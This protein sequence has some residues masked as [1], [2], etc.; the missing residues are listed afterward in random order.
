MAS[1]GAGAGAREC[2]EI[3]FGSGEGWSRGS[4]R[5]YAEIHFGSGMG[6][7]SAGEV[8]AHGVT[9]INFGQRAG[10]PG[11]GTRGDLLRGCARECAEMYCDSVGK[12]FNA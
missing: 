4:A 5:A 3:D 9:E 7:G 10:V 12:V 2:A 6:Q 11:A 1:E 8:Q